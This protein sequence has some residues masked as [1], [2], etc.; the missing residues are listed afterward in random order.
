VVAE[1]F[2]DLAG[3][4]SFGGADGDLAVL[5]LV[6]GVAASDVAGGFASVSGLGDDDG[7][8]GPVGLSV[9]APVEPMMLLAS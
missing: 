4:V 1:G 9:P 6:V 2:P 8:D 5:L 3:D 7:V